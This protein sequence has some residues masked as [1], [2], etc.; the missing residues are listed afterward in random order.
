MYSIFPKLCSTNF[1]VLTRS[2]TTCSF[3]QICVHRSKIICSVHLSE[4]YN[5][6]ASMDMKVSNIYTDVS[7]FYWIL[8]CSYF[9]PLKLHVKLYSMLPIIQHIR[10][11]SC[12]RRWTP[13]TSCSGIWCSIDWKSSLPCLFPSDSTYFSH[14]ASSIYSLTQIPNPSHFSP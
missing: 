11:W 12:R 4:D 3:L 9:H 7:S 10:K 6:F 13:N 5:L 8:F 2:D 1:D 14:V